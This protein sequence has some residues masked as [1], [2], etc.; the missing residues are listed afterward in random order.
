MKGAA[1]DL[2][3]TDFK[4]PRNAKFVNIN[5]IREAFRPGT[6]P[7]IVVTPSALTREGLPVRPLTYDELNRRSGETLPAP[8]RRPDEMNGL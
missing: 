6:E 7:K 3:R 4:A 2:P 1:K 5:G 8:E